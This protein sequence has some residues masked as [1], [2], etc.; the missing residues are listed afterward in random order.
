M[1]LGFETTSLIF[2]AKVLMGDKHGLLWN[3]IIW[4]I[5]NIVT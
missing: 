2:E 5:A 3:F 1:Y 4:E